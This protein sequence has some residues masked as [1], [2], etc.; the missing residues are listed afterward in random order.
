MHHKYA[1]IDGTTL[2][3]GSYNWTR[4]GEY[5]NKENLIIWRSPGMAKLFLDEFGRIE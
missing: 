5:V 2:I 4:N 3:L 1:V